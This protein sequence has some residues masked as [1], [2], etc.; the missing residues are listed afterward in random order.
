[1]KV[2]TQYGFS[3]EV[4]PHS[5]FARE[6]QRSEGN[7]FYRDGMGTYEHYESEKVVSLVRP[8]DFCIDAGAHIG[9]FSCL[10]AHA[11]ADV[12]A[13]EPNPN[14]R[15]MLFANAAQFDGHICGVTAALGD[16]TGPTEYHVPP[17]TDDGLGSIAWPHV[18]PP[19][20]VHML[21]LD[22][23]LTHKRVRLL[24]L[25]VE[26]SE[27]SVLRGL[28]ECLA[29]VEY[30]LMECASS[31]TEVPAI[32]ELLHGWKIQRCGLGEWRVMPAA[33]PDGDYLFTNPKVTV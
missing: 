10:M 6:I 7:P 8:G 16:H 30:I 24:K 2:A 31:N 3:L 22:G 1:M 28:G 33:L 19:F 9:Y 11:G 18:G 13:F 29:N 15:E 32:N 14:L 5:F 4:N 20:S 21:R 27:L 17:E 25:D 12:I 26:G 23:I